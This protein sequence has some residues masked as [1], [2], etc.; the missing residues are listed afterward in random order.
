MYAISV[1][2]RLQVKH[3]NGESKFLEKTMLEEAGNVLG[4]IAKMVKL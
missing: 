4:N 2:E 3:I 1:H